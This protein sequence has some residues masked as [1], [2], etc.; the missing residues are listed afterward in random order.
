MQNEIF[1]EYYGLAK[2]TARQYFN[3]ELDVES[4]ALVALEKLFLKFPD[5]SIE[6]LKEN[7]GYIYRMIRNAC[8]SE[9]RK[10]QTVSKRNVLSDDFSR[11]KDLFEELNLDEEDIRLS[12]VEREIQTLSDREKKIIQLK[13]EEGYSYKEISQ[14]INVHPNNVGTLYSRII[15]KLKDKLA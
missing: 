1:N 2:M 13:F 6:E 10:S 3:N 14:A 15:K 9:L 5:L 4:A 11:V 8:V 12:K 7:R